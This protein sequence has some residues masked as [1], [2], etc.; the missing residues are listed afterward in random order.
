[1]VGLKIRR[2]PVAVLH[3]DTTPDGVAQW[4]EHSPDDAAASTPGVAAGQ[5]RSFVGDKVQTGGSRPVTFSASEYQGLTPC[6]AR[7][8]PCVVYGL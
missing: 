3:I 8:V 7:S 5:H 6:S 2:T 1:M 4:A